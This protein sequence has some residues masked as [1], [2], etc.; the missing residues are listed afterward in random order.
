MAIPEELLGAAQCLLDHA[1]D[2]AAKHC[3]KNGGL[4]HCLQRACAAWNELLE[5]IDQPIE[6]TEADT[7]AVKIQKLIPSREISITR[8]LWD[9]GLITL[10]NEIRPRLAALAPSWSCHLGP[11]RRL[12]EALAAIP[13][14]RVSPTP[15]VAKEGSLSEFPQLMSADVVAKITEFAANSAPICGARYPRI[16][17]LIR[18]GDTAEGGNRSRREPVDGNAT[19]PAAAKRATVKGACTAA[20]KHGNRPTKNDD[21]GEGEDDKKEIQT[22]PV[23]RSRGK[24]PAPPRTR[25]PTG[26]RASRG[27]GRGRRRKPRLRRKKV[28]WDEGAG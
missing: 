25:T 9:F 22:G 2:I 18:E 7:E 24:R 17:L 23:T 3:R 15:G 6:L 26:T 13:S 20:P 27:S 19:N 11:A 16:R 4:H 8:L 12:R 14:P 28:P 10:E 21:D 5:F 1:R